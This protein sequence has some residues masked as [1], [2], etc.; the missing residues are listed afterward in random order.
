MT[1]LHSCHVSCQNH[2]MQET[3]YIRFVIEM[4]LHFS[5][6]FKPVNQTF[7]RF[8]VLQNNSHCEANKLWAILSLQFHRLDGFVLICLGS[9]KEGL[10]IEPWIE[11]TGPNWTSAVQGPATSHSQQGWQVQIATCRSIHVSHTNLI[12]HSSEQCNLFVFLSQSEYC[13]EYWIFTAVDQA[14][15]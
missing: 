10:P 11:A 8:P 3:A 9:T 7:S 1:V 4:I 6:K 5:C 14:I 12:S 2:V 13:I 15:W